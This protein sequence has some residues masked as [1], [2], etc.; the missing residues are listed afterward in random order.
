MGTIRLKMFDN[1]EM[2]LQEVR[3][4]PELKRNLLS[5]G[6]F[7]LIG[8]TTKIEQGVVK[9]QKGASTVAKEVKKNGLY[10]LEGS[11]I[12]AHTSVASQTMQDKTKLWHLRLG[13]ISERDLVE[14]NKQKLLGDDRMEELEFCDH[15]ILGKSHRLKFET[16]KHASSRPFEYAHADL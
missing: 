15:C 14:L 13:H 16:G 4:V 12:I 11:T 6:M 8:L 9:I 3:Y 7:D 10:L 2:L 5:M 1:W